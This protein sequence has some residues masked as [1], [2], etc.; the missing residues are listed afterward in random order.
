MTEET[1]KLNQQ[2]LFEEIADFLD[3]YLDAMPPEVLRDL[4]LGVILEP[5]K[6]MSPQGLIMGEYRISALGN[7]IVLYFGSF[8][9]RFPALPVE[10]LKYE[11]A[12]TL[13]HE[14]THHVEHLAGDYSL[15]KE[16]AR[17][18]E[19]W[20]RERMERGEGKDE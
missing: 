7:G 11:V 5:E 8:L 15:A 2:E 9:S 4:H 3:E 1:Q 13:R 10:L 20:Y 14:L 12:A 16:E 18:R 6:K 19:E 17:E